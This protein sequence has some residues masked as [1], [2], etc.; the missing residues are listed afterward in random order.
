MPKQNRDGLE[1]ARCIPWMHYALRALHQWFEHDEPG[2]KALW[3]GNTD[4]V[5]NWMWF[6]RIARNYPGLQSHIG[7]LVVAARNNGNA[8]KDMQGTDSALVQ[9][10]REIARTVDDGRPR[11]SAASKLLYLAQPEL[12]VI[13]DRNACLALGLP[14][15]V[16]YAQF[17]QRWN[18]AF[19][20]KESQ[21]RKGLAA[22]V[23]LPDEAF[24]LSLADAG[25]CRRLLKERWFARRVFDIHLWHEGAQ[26]DR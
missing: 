10:V 9:A 16:D 12:G 25:R 3:E 8:I 18:G 6:Y 7:R 24:P 2:S 13:Y 14:A 11:V 23:G 15:Q 22:T 19:A 1:G 20:E 21:I 26:A 4:R 5:R 17:L